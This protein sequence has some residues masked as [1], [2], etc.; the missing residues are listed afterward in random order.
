[1]I[2]IKTNL[3]NIFKNYYD[4]EYHH[5]LWTLNIRNSWYQVL[6]KRDIHLQK[7]W[8]RFDIN[9]TGKYLTKRNILGCLLIFFNHNLLR[10]IGSWVILYWDSILYLKENK[11]KSWEKCSSD[12]QSFAMWAKVTRIMTH[13]LNF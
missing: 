7:I 12:C 3:S 13:F 2:I 9:E 6:V 4:C 8:K 11:K 5:L 1:M 10:N